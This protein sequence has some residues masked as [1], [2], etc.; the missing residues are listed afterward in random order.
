MYEIIF[1]YN[2]MREDGE[3]D[4]EETKTKV[5]K[6][7]NSI[8]EEVP[9][10]QVAG[11]IM[12]Q[13]ARKK[14][15][16]VEVRIFEYTKKELT[17][18]EEDDG[19]KIGR[20]KFSFE[21]GALIGNVKEDEP[22][23]QDKLLALLKSNPQLLDQ[24]SADRRQVGLEPQPKLV[25]ASQ[26]KNAV[27]SQPNIDVPQ[28]YEVFD[29]EVA[30]EGSTACLEFIKRR[31]WKFTSGKRYPIFQEKMGPGGL[32]YSTVDDAGVRLD[33]SSLY[34]VP[35]NKGLTG[36]FIEDAQGSIGP[37]GPEP[38]LMYQSNQMPNLRA[39]GNTSDPYR[40]PNLRGGR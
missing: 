20:K 15:S 31:N 14:I 29:P 17:F 3:F 2:E 19:F 34:F 25:T 12:A 28:R 10:E 24:L 40:M 11:K 27:T 32:L 16:V 7:G 37:V 1:K 22:S 26:S 21:D 18:R 36:T 39:T 5:I 13:L 35:P 23:E 8:D 4:I 38:K 6:I 30:P 33:V 9:L